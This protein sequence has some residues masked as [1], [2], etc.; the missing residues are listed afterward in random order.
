MRLK[1]WQMW[2]LLIF[3]LYMMAKH[4][5]A[6]GQALHNLETGLSGFSRGAGGG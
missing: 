2:L 3:F 4:G 1:P 5:Y 6:M